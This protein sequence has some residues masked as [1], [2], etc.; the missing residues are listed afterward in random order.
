[1]FGL[2]VDNLVRETTRSADPILRVFWGRGG[3]AMDKKVI[4][5]GGK[6][7]AIFAV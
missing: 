2:T 1:M 7:G 3:G 6:Y 4:E 5:L